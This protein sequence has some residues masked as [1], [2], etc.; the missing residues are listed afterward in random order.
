[1]TKFHLLIAAAVSA[2]AASPAVA[3]PMTA[4]DLQ[5]MHR[6]GSPVVSPDGRTAIFTVS[7]T[8]WSKNERVN[9]L[10]RL[11]LTRA[12]AQPLAIARAQKGHDAMFSGDGTLWFLMPVGEQEQLFRMAPG[13]KPVQV[14]SFHGDVGGFKVSDAGNMV[15]VWAD[16]YLRC[17]DLNCA[18]L[19]D[20]PKSG[21]GRTYDQL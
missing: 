21:A 7:D 2:L 18:S 10:Y 4:V 17:T 14:S 19:P 12:G 1:M 11:D 16:R 8:D 9:R 15:V 20:E 13:G 5:S 6:L 3:R